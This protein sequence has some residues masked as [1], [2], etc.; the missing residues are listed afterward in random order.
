MEQTRPRAETDAT[1]AAADLAPV[2]LEASAQ[3]LR[4]FPELLAALAGAPPS[5]RVHLA[6]DVNQ[7][8]RAMRAPGHEAE[9]AELVM[10]ALSS[11]VLHDLEDSRGH[12]C[13]REAVET[14]LACGFPHA[15]LLEPDDVAFA[16]ERGDE[17]GEVQLSPWELAMQRHRRVGAAVMTVG[18][19]AALLAIVANGGLGRF[20]DP[21]MLG[22]AVA[23]LA[24]AAVLWRTR[25]RDLNTGTWGM[26][27]ILIGVAGIAVATA[28]GSWSAAIAP[29][30][31]MVGLFAALGPLY[32]ELADEPHPG[33]WD[34]TPRNWK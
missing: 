25:P 2:D 23:G 8:L 10:G 18:Q 13:R 3:R 11:K 15:L 4:S 5:E 14:M 26:L 17:T 21:A 31:V 30:G 19:L 34:F 33:E 9:E 7:V 22:L 27:S 29:L 28:V 6:D 16:R 12:S 20:G 32:E 24:C 1:E